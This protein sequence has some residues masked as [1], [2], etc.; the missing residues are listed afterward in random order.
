M[1]ILITGGHGL[2]GTAIGKLFPEAYRPTHQELDITDPSHDLTLFDIV[3]HCAAIKTTECDTDPLQAMEVNIV[4]TANLVRQCY[5]AQAKLVYI[6]T[7]YVFRGDR[8]NYKPDDEV[9]PQ[10]YYAETKLA[11][12]YAVKCLPKYL[13]IR[14]SFYPDQFPYDKAFTDQFT[15]RLPVTEAASKIATLVR[16]DECGVR[17]VGGPRQSVY[18]FAVSTSKGKCIQK[19]QLSDHPYTRPRDVSLDTG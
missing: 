2:L 16:K 9:D 7:D 17:H 11:G 19:M 18:D 13:I 1:K 8:G 15:S 4:G 10:N 5:Y 12:E 3:I 6:S 14:T